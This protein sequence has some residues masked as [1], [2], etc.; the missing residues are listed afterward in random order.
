MTFDVEIGSNTWRA[1]VAHIEARVA[2]LRFDLEA[3]GHEHTP[4]IDAG[5]RARIAELLSILQL[6]TTKT[7]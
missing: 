5:R 4:T 6:G 7:P 3:E 1:I 2:E